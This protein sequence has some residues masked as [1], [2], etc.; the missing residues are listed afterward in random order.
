VEASD[1][2]HA[3]ADGH[4][5]KVLLYTIKKRLSEPHFRTGRSRGEKK[6]FVP[7]ETRRIKLVSWS[8]VVSLHTACTSGQGLA[9]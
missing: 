1:Q 5:G 9:D 6:Y 7:A 3:S 4:R 8:G 2:L